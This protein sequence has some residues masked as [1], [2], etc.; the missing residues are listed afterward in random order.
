MQIELVQHILAD[1]FQQPWVAWAALLSGPSAFIILCVLQVINDKRYQ[2]KEEHDSVVKRLEQA[3]RENMRAIE[4][5]QESTTLQHETLRTSLH[6]LRGDMNSGFLNITQVV[7]DGIL[8]ISTE[9]AET[10]GRIA[11]SS[12]DHNKEQS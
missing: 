9:V 7:N 3:D 12:R 1:A 2:R 10:R 6:N 5:L 4:K 8:K 11:G